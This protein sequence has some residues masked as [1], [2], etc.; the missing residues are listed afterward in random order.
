MEIPGVSFKTKILCLRYSQET[1]KMPAKAGRTTDGRA[2][3]HAPA[4]FPLPSFLLILLRYR[5][6]EK[7]DLAAVV[8]KVT[9]GVQ[10]TWQIWDLNQLL[11]QLPKLNCRRKFALGLR[12]CN[13]PELSHQVT[14]PT[15]SALK[16]QLLPPSL[17]PPSWRALR[18]SDYKDL[19]TLPPLGK[20]HYWGQF[21]DSS[22]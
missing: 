21:A 10:W 15:S 16:W 19:P 20:V 5:K 17:P 9:N 7:E 12:H 18:H 11:S 1:Y 22:L 8:I 4:I 6:E 13:A 2:L 3:L 14:I